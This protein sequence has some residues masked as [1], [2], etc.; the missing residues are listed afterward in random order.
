MTQ[1]NASETTIR[2]GSSLAESVYQQVKQAIVTGA[3]APRLQVTE[4]QIAARLNVSRTP[5]HQAVVLLEKEGWLRQL[6]KRGLYICDLNATEMQDIY[7]VL[8]GLEGIAAERLAA[9]SKPADDHIDERI[10]EAALEAENALERDDLSAWAD[11]DYKFHTMLVELCGNPQLVRLARSVMEKS[12][13]ARLVTL[14]H[15]PRPEQATKDHR[16][17]VQAIKLRDP[18]AAREALISH[19]KKGIETLIPILRKMRS[20]STFLDD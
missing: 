3:L 7:E 5:V 10:E 14:E 20:R 2:D 12:H 18:I 1:T 4:Q 11:A 9:R 19:R 16:E 8:M 17:I 13:Q 15:R 6:P